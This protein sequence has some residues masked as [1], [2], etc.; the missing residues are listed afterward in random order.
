MSL[1]TKI[2]SAEVGDAEKIAKIY[3]ESLEHGIANYEVLPH[4]TT[5]RRDWLISLMDRGF[6][7]LVAEAN[8]DICGFCALTPFHPSPGYRFTVTGSIYV[9]VTHIR[10]G[11]GQ[12]L[13]LQ[14]IAEARR[15]NFH[16]IIA[17]INSLNESS[18]AFHKSLGFKQA[19]LFKDI[20]CRDGRWYDDVC[21]QLI[22]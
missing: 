14:I 5:Q 20:G 2:R 15:K 22:L 6:P 12:S 21:L 4:T 17:G 8:T 11:I 7:V 19:G 1:V 3:N 16:T 13:A 9:T 18:I 10:Q